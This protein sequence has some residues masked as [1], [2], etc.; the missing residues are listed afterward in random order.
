MTTDDEHHNGW[1]TS[2]LRNTFQSRNCGQ[3]GY[4]DCLVVCGQSDPP[5]LSKCRGDHYPG[6]VLLTDCRNISKTSTLVNRK[7]PIL[8]Y[9]NTLPQVAQT[10]LR[11]MHELGQETSPHPPHSP[12]LS[13]TEYH[14]F[15]HLDNILR[16]RSFKIQGYAETAFDDFIA[17]RTAEFHSSGINKL[18]SRWE[19][20]V[21][22]NGF[23]S[24]RNVTFEPL[25][26]LRLK[27][28]NNFITNLIPLPEKCNRVRS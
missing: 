21:D 2:K 14:F 20:C 23:I 9:D 12:D 4:G 11:K 19:K 16:K 8:R 5:Q 28:R 26:S 22:A 1:I 24:N 18:G 25:L 3:K 15:K 7:M 6:E 13:T 17:I 10:I 27:I